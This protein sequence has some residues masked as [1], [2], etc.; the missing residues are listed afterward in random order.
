ME[1]LIGMTL[2]AAGIVLSMNSQ[3]SGV[4]LSRDCFIFGI[5]LFVIC[6]ILLTIWKR[7]SENRQSN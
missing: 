6:L 5:P 3:Q 7:Y 4:D 1:V 2:I